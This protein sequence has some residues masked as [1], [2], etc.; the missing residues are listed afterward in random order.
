MITRFFFSP[1]LFF[2]LRLMEGGRF[3]TVEKTRGRALLT[4]TLLLTERKEE[5]QHES[6]YKTQNKQIIILIIIMPGRG[7]K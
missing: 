5:L 6:C 7:K 1:S 3:S 4:L 2:L